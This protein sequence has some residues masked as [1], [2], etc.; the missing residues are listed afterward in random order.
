[1]ENNINR[2]SIE[3]MVSEINTIPA[4]TAEVRLPKIKLIVDTPLEGL[5]RNLGKNATFFFL[6]QNARKELE[7]DI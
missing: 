3:S 4:Q 1:M 5:L 2:E 6:L 7:C